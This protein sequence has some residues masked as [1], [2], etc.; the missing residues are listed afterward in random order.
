MRSR[1][2]VVAKR[3]TDWTRKAGFWAAPWLLIAAALWV[4]TPTLGSELPD[5]MNL[6]YANIIV[7]FAAP[8]PSSEGD[9]AALSEGPAEI[10]ARILSR[11]EPEVRRSARIFDHL[12]LIALMADAESMLRLIAMPEVLAIQ[13]DRELEM[14]PSPAA[15]DISNASGDGTIPDDAEEIAVPDVSG[16]F[17]IPEVPAE[18]A[19]DEDDQELPTQDE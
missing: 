4:S 7:E 12:P 19:T 2:D 15:A 8:V 13:P 18:V 3:D 10:A 5:D 1:N 16:E 6:S 17:T 14:L 9:E 11:L